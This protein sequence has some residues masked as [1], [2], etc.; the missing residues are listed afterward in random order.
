MLENSFILARGIGPQRERSLWRSGIVTW[1]E[2]LGESQIRGISETR[3]SEMDAQLSDAVER[4]GSGDWGYFA[5]R[6][7]SRERWR[8]L[9]ELGSSIAYLDIET[10]GTS[11]RSPIT[12]VGIYDGKRMHTLVRG[13]NLDSTNLRA[14]LGSA[15]ALVTYN[16]ASFD[17]PIIEYQF[18]RCVPK[19]PHIDLRHPLRRLGFSGG[20]KN[21]ERELGIERDKR[22]EYMTGEDAVY[23]WKLWERKGSRNALDLLREYN[24]EDCRNLKALASYAYATLKRCTFDAAI[25]S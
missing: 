11:H 13:Q 21:V 8:C 22:V 14:I 9:K 12:L 20:L 1:R 17:L 5:E 15:S 3:K 7:P 4:L 16:G 24:A 25:R 18:P 19:I 10:T 6:V 23:L 2:F